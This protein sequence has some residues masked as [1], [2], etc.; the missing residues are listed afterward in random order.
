MN[1]GTF[2]GQNALG[3]S[4]VGRVTENI[5]L[6]T[7]IGTGMSRGTVGGRAGVTVAW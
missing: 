5:F 4:G 3:F 1:W 6:N 2:N 7:G